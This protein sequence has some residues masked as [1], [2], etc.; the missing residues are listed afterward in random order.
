MT[1]DSF[2]FARNIL[3]F[4]LIQWTI[5]KLPQCFRKSRREKMK[6]R[7]FWWSIFTHDTEVHRITNTKRWGCFQVRSWFLNNFVVFSLWT[8]TFRQRKKIELSILCACLLILTLRPQA[9]FITF[10]AS[11]IPSHSPISLLTTQNGAENYQNLEA[12]IIQRENW[13]W[14]GSQLIDWLGVLK[15]SRHW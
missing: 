2:F 9:R 10:P 5:R 3:N 15:M 8:K 11:P 13:F 12:S 14:N 4:V 7:K 6:N 1:I